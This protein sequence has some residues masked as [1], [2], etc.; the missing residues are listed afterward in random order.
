MADALSRINSRVQKAAQAELAHRAEFGSNLT[1][2]TLVGAKSKVTIKKDEAYI[3]GAKVDDFVI[4]SKKLLLGASFK[5]VVLGVL[6]VYAE[7]T[8]PVAQGDMPRT[9]GYW[10]PSDAEQVPLEGNFNR[11]LPNGNHLEAQHWAMLYLP[12]HPELEGVVLSFKGVGNQYAKK[13]QKMLKEAST[14]S[15]ELI[16]EFTAEQVENKKY[17]T[18]NSYPVAEIVGKAFDYD[19]GVKLVKD[20]FNAETV[21]EICNRYADVYDAYD[22]GAMIAKHTY[23]GPTEIGA[24][25]TMALEDKTDGT[26]HAEVVG[27]DGNTIP[28]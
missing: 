16:V 7:M 21:E 13:L 26:V 27:D 20:S 23:N 15:P 8:T 9:A 6:K 24:R 19:D 12:D 18:Y 5:A 17:S 2:V 1:W 28:F 3:P 22:H 25:E 4:A 11:P 10:H 14:I